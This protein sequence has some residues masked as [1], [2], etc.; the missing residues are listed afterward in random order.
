EGIDEGVVLALRNVV[1]VLD[2]DN[3]GD[4]LSFL[5]L[6]GSDVAQADVAN[7]SLTFQLGKDS[8][9]LLDGTFGWLGNS[10]D[11]QIHDVEAFHAEI[12]EIVLSAGEQIL[13]GKCG[14]PRF[15]FTAAGTQFG[16]DDQVFWVRMEGF[17][18][19]LIGYMRAVKI[20][21][22]DMNYASGDRFTQD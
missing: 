20:A 19:D 15:V 13:T 12:A 17:L 8:D 1:E 6:R 14:Y 7:Q 3:F 2:A 4:F 10:T 16:Y 11:A 21:G 9:L 18:D 22:V 5:E